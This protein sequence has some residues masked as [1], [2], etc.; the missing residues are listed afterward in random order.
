MPANA[1]YDFTIES[2]G[3]CKVASPIKMAKAKDSFIAEYVGDNEV[4][5][6]DIVTT[7]DK[8]EK[9]FT[10]KQV[11]ER[12]GPRE[13]IYFDPAKVHAGIVTC[14]G[15]CPGLN[16]VIRAIVMCLWY[17]YGVRRIS[18][19]RYGYR[20]LLPEF[21][22]PVMELNPDRVSDIHHHGGTLLGSSRGGGDQVP[23]MVDEIE[24]MNLN[25]LFVIG[26]DG[27]QKGARAIAQESQ[28]R[29]FKLAVV[30]IPK[31]ID[32]DLC[33]IERS[34]G[35]NTA[36]AEAVRVVG[37]AH[38]E[39]HDA[40]NGVAIVKLMGRQSGYIAAH[41]GL[42]INDVNF[43][44]I[45]EVPFDLEGPNVLF[46]HLKARLDSRHHAVIVAAEG[47]GQHFF[48]DDTGIDAS[49][50]KKLGDIGA[51]LRDQTARYF[52]SIGMEINIRYIDP[53]YIIRSAPADPSDSL[54]CVRLGTHAVHAAMAGKTKLLMSLVNDH[55]VHVP[56]TM[57]VSERNFVDPEGSLWRDV[58]NATGQPALMTNPT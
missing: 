12:A 22:L 42:A 32:N 24:R 53:S 17:H 3:A 34:F 37:G 56:I 43:V 20:G 57:A 16:D 18:G 10:Q 11:L 28:S 35:F 49:G 31:T 4:I 44:L 27:S 50:N 39:A 2:L 5:L 47:A 19:I 30:G 38:V 55:F 1:T 7:I 54:Y 45:P 48:K 25:M 14:G 33:F 58:V 23:A 29:G 52:K 8:L 46:A 41:T 6:Y 36:V 9:Q 21:H 26:G 15:L 51:F 13:K 40:I